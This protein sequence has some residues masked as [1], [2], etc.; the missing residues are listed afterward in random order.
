MGDPALFAAALSASAALLTVIVGGLI[1]TRRYVILALIAL[2]LSLVAGQLVRLPLPGQ[3]GGALLS[4]ITALAVIVG[5]GMVTVKKRSLSPSLMAVAAL[6][7]IF[8]CWAPLMLFISLGTL[9]TSHLIISL[10]YWVRLA[11]LL[12]LIPALCVLCEDEK[13][14]K[15]LRISSVGAGAALIILGFIQYM[16]VPD[17]A[18]LAPAGW[19][20]HIGR[21]VSTWLDPN[22]FGLF[23]LLYILLLLQVKK[24]YPLMWLATAMLTILALVATQS[25]SSWLAGGAIIFIAPYLIISLRRSL[26]PATVRAGAAA[27]GALLLTT[28]I[29]TTLFFYDRL[30]GLVVSDATVQ[31]RADSLRVAWSAVVEPHWLLGVGYNAFG[32][33]AQKAGLIADFL[34]HSRSGIDNSFLALWATTGV[35]GLTLFS[36]MWTLIAAKLVSHWRTNGSL[37]PLIALVAIGVL[38]THAL[39]TNSFLYAHAFTFLA[40]IIALGWSQPN[41]ESV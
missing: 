28:V 15:S 25:R 12:A 8:L 7:G 33:Y 10:A 41:V 18:F 3:G 21:L 35:V 34:T 23:C 13:S 14:K 29:I 11:T 2:T 17:L 24:T 4:D 31:L 26:H 19:D 36:G 6:A 16:F 38:T 1:W 22:F 30:A 32:W 5:A 40:I 37:A 9:P 20:P 27:I 39:F